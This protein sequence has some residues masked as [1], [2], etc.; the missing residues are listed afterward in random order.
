MRLFSA[1]QREI[2]SSHL[3]RAHN[4]GCPLSPVHLVYAR[5]RGTERWASSGLLVAGV[6]TGTGPLKVV[7]K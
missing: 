5:I 2:V 1:M 7:R 4:G 3:M 6:P